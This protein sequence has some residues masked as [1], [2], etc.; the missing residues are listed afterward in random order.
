MPVKPAFRTDVRQHR[1]GILPL[2]VFVYDTV[3]CWDVVPNP[4]KGAAFGIRKLLCTKV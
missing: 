3:Y 1:K 2:N 4:T